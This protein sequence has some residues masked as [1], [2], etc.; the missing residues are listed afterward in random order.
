[1]FSA[2]MSVKMFIVL[3]TR[4]SNQWPETVERSAFAFAPLTD[5]G[6][7]DVWQHL[8]AA[9]VSFKPK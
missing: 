9:L 8:V 1:M 3:V 2:S 6:D 4:T 5:Q 7:L